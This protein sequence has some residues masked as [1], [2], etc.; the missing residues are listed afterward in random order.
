MQDKILRVIQYF[1][2]F[3]FPPTFEEIYLFLE[4]PISKRQLQEDL[5]YLVKKKFILKQNLWINHQSVA[6]YTYVQ[7]KFFFQVR[8]Q[9]EIIALKKFEK[10]H[11][12]TKLLSWLPQ[13]KFVGFSGSIAMSNTS[14][15][16]D[17]DLFIVTSAKRMWTARFIALFLAQLL[18]LRGK[19]N[20]D[21]VCLNMFF[22]EQDVE[23]PPA[24]R[25][26]YTAHEIF[27]MKVCINKGNIYE[28]L[29][30]QN[31]WAYAFFP[32]MPAKRMYR[33][34]STANK[35]FG[36]ILFDWLELFLKKIQLDKLQRGKTYGAITEIQLWL[37]KEDFEK[38]IPL[39][40]K[41]V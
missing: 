11:F 30:T 10:V 23:L 31:K 32:N 6:C 35:W 26:E 7:R 33:V 12:Y 22:D 27:Q 20:V 38:K 24:K 8:V 14:E 5:D 13:I 34:K 9:R 3:S 41:R 4:E 18:R 37:I 15:D 1:A 19:Y 39:K 40:L 17:I 25:N 29:L 28:K 21:K 36:R 16:D 2:V